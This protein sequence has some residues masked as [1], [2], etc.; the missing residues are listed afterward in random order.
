M[1]KWQWLLYWFTMSTTIQGQVFPKPDSG[2]TFY[3]VVDSFFAN[4]NNDGAEG[5]PYRYMT[6]Q[7]LIW[8]ERLAPDGKME[9]ASKSIINSS[10]A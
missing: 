3:H 7:N 9:H 2:A 8:G 1:K 10:Y 6:R 4:N 5:G